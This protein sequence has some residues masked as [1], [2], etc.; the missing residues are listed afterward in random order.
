MK[1]LIKTNG[2]KKCFTLGGGQ[3]FYALD[4]VNIM[5]PEKSLTIFKG[6]SGSGKTTLL[7]VI[8]GLDYATEGSVYF[9][10]QDINV[11]KE[12]K[13]ETIRRYE[14]GYVFQSVA[15]IPNMNALENVE[16]GLRLA[17]Y[18]GDREKRAKDCLM[19]VG[20]G[21][22]MAHM[23]N[24][25]SGGEQQRVAIARALCHKPKVIFADEP[26]GAL[27]TTMALQVM[28]LFKELVANEEITIVMTTHDPELMKAGD[29]V[30]EIND[31]KIISSEELLVNLES[32][33]GE[34]NGK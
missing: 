2:V 6:R 25:L 10:G 20:L 12:S 11:M 9:Q 3:K 32:E 22:R 19:Q 34:H 28:N 14:M 29:V 1:E 17:E 30:Y 33:R 8:S 31:G 27:D 23:P 15:L 24:E 7:N 26:T 18:K 4:G 16:F 13:R 21:K 5:I